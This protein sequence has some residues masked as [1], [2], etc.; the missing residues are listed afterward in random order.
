MDIYQEDNGS[1]NQDM[2]RPLGKTQGALGVNLHQQEQTR[3]PLQRVELSGFLIARF[4]LSASQSTQTGERLQDYPDPKMHLLRTWA[5]NSF[6][7]L[8]QAISFSGHRTDWCRN[9]WNGSSLKS[10]TV[11]IQGIFCT[12]TEICNE[13]S[14]SKPGDRIKYLRTR[15][16]ALISPASIRWARWTP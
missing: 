15:A 11:V 13:L 3:M 4:T 10:M 8:S 9:V 6:S 5:L 1:I 7:H 12:C 16:I 2:H 14:P